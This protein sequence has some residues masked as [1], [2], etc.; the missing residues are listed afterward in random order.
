MAFGPAV[1]RGHCIPRPVLKRKRA[2]KSNA[3]KK[4]GDEYGFCSSR[5][6]RTF[7]SASEDEKKVKEEKTF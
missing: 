2:R 1:T 4:G 3:R 7:S 5:D 6:P